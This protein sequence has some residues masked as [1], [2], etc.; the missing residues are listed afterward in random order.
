MLNRK[1][2]A[3]RPHRNTGYGRYKVIGQNQMK[4]RRKEKGMERDWK[5]AIAAR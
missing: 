3:P 2:G 4:E 1:P 5:G